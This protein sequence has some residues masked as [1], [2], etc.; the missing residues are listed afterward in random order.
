MGLVNGPIGPPAVEEGD[1]A[2]L[3]LKKK[4]HSGKCYIGLMEWCNVRFGLNN[5][6]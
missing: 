1:I 3:W 4:K 6:A 5:I 2:T